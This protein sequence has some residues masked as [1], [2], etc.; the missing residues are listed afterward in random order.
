M[1]HVI[2]PFNDERPFRRILSGSILFYL[3][4]AVLTAIYPLPEKAREEIG[5]LPPRIAKLVLEPPQEIPKPVEETPVTE[6]KEPAEKKVEDEAQKNREVARKSGLLKHLSREK[7]GLQSILQSAELG[8]ILQDT[9]ALTEAAAPPSAARAAV[10]AVTGGIGSTAGIAGEL[11]VS[12]EIGLGEKKTL[13]TAV[14]RR[15]TE[16]LRREGTRGERSPDSIAGIVASYRGG[17]DFVYKKTLRENPL[18]K[19]TITVEF[20]I[21]PNGEVIQ[22]RVVSSTLNDPAFEELL[23]KRILQWKFPP[24]P[25]VQNATVTYP[26]EFSP[27]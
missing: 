1:A 3:I 6:K 24:L 23:V 5:E 20:T 14:P 21:A 8:E 12:S 7:K 26:L 10:P 11:D 19:G 17:I 27:V 4:L 2:R 22:C 18:L 16:N 9:S 15:K 25:G 13:E